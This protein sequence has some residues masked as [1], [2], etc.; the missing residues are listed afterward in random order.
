MN[1]K[2]DICKCKSSKGN[3][4]GRVRETGGVSGFPYKMFACKECRDRIKRGF[5]D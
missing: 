2:C 4:I 3:R 5:D 1:K